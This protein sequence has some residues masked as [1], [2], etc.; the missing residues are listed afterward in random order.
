MLVSSPV[1]ATVVSLS[2]Y[3]MCLDFGYDLENPCCCKWFCFIRPDVMC[4]VCSLPC[5]PTS[6]NLETGS[7]SFISSFLICQFVILNKNVQSNRV[8]TL[9]CNFQCYFSFSVI[10]MIW[11]VL[12]ITTNQS[13]VLRWPRVWALIYDLVKNITDTCSE[14]PES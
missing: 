2:V 1:N 10:L 7:R 11:S 4:A 14:L 9:V 6:L 8:V 12:S 3:V 13:S 5:D